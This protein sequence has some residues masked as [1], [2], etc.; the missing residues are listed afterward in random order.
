MN[1]FIFLV[2][3]FL[4]T[5]TQVK[6]QSINKTLLLGEWF[7]VDKT[8]NQDTLTFIKI[9]KDS[10][11]LKWDFSKNDSL[12]ISNGYFPNFEQMKNC[13]NC[14]LTIICS[15]SDN[16]K[17]FIDTQTNILYIQ[18]LPRQNG[19]GRAKRKKG[20]LDVNDQYYSSEKYTIVELNSEN[21][22]LIKIKN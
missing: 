22:K 19:S 11:F 20:T 9:Q 21:L 12:N 8:N 3:I 14:N 18:K 6:S 15:Q 2:F 13:K 16:Y 4:T 10:S 7:L 5:F 17:W 1:K